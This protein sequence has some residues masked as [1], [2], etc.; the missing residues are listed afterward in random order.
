MLNILQNAVWLCGATS[1]ADVSVQ[2]VWEQC[3]ALSSANRHKVPCPCD[4]VS[5]FSAVVVA[6]CALLDCVLCRLPAA[7]QHCRIICAT[8][9]MKQHLA[10]STLQRLADG[11][12]PVAVAAQ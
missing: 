4:W 2:H 10:Q 6:C 1:D 5:G 8:V 9:N 3:T 11:T 7:Q 12:A